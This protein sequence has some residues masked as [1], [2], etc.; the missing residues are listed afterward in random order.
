VGFV[1]CAH[2][3]GFCGSEVDEERGSVQCLGPILRRH[4]G[5][6]KDGAGNVIGGSDG[7]LFLA[8]LGG[9]LGAG[10]AKNG[11]VRS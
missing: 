7:A 1:R 6:E 10:E 2:V 11:T 4:G 8:I 3:E 5:M 9:C